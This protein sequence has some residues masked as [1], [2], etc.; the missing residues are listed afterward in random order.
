MRL[1]SEFLQADGRTTAAN[2]LDPAIARLTTS[3]HDF[4]AGDGRD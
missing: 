1:F 2:K 3:C 4:G